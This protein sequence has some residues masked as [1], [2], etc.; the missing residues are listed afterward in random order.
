M[1]LAA[2]LDIITA[3]ALTTL[4]FHTVATVVLLAIARAPGWE[5]AR[6]VTVLAATAG[7]YSLVDLHG[8]LRQDTPSALALTTTINM[9]VAA[10]HAAC[11]LWFTFSDE[12]GAWRSV[13]LG[14]RR[15]GIASVAITVLLSLLD[16]VV[17][18]GVLDRVSVPA[19]GVDFL[20]PRLSGMASLA[21]VLILLTLS[22]SFIAFVSRARRGVNGARIMA[23]GFAV[24]LLCSVEEGLVSTGAL[25]FI[26]LA[27]VGYLALITP[28]TML[29]VRRFTSDARRLS[30]LT[31]RL[32]D[33]VDRALGERDIAREALAAQERM[34]AL[35]RIAGGIGHEVNNPLQYLTFSLEEIRDE[36]A[37]LRGVHGDEAITN[38]FDAI[39]R[40]RRVVDG[41]RAYSTPVRQSADEVDL[42]EVVRAALRLSASQLRGVPIV[43]KRLDPVPPVRGEEGKLVQAVVNAVLNA[44]HV[45]RSHPPEGIASITVA[46]QALPDG[47]A[48]IEI[49]DNGPGFPLELIPT[50]GQPFVTTRAT[51][52]GSGLGIFVIRGIV[53]A[54]GGSVTLANAPEGGAVLRIR[55]PVRRDAQGTMAVASISTSAPASIRDETSTAV[56]AG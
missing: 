41:L 50:L 11:W 12:K 15:L 32:A 8:A 45:L 39:D 37:G 55:L 9:S 10:I 30:T 28:V 17:T 22:T 13:P 40:I 5:R 29:L 6:I 7:L 56:M 1:E 44:V 20:Q 16:L 4:A 42:H 25:D 34:A 33:E 43:Q 18:P 53:D 26:Y 54:H 21:A 3:M 48:E 14:I 23:A 24:F 36:T 19:L 31:H 49:R 51:E 52:G 38:A 47:G 46:T 2:R 35:G 27:E